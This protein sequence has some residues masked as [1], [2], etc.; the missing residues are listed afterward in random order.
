LSKNQFNS[1]QEDP[2]K[3]LPAVVVARGPAFFFTLLSYCM[4]MLHSSSEEKGLPADI[5]EASSSEV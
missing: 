3:S 2:L 4:E 5:E 1:I